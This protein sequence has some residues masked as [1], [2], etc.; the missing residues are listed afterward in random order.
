MA[1]THTTTI[2]SL[3]EEF[4]DDQ[5]LL[6]LGTEW[7]FMETARQLDHEEEAPTPPAT[8]PNIDHE[9]NFS[10][11]QTPQNEPEPAISA[12]TTGGTN[13]A[14]NPRRHPRHFDRGMSVFF[15]NFFPIMVG[16]TCEGTVPRVCQVLSVRQFYI[17]G[18]KRI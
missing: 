11:E 16:S 6:M 15:A 14:P 9:P 12:A 4:N 2:E 5:L 13:R 10:A 3:L 8:R 1:K 7:A 17:L 18:V